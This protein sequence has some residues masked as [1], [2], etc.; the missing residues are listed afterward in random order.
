MGRKG[1]AAMKHEPITDIVERK[2]DNPL[3]T[4][5]Q[6]LHELDTGVRDAGQI[7]V[8]MNLRTLMGGF[9]R[10][11][12]TEAQQKAAARL[13]TLHERAQVG[14]ARAVDPSREPVDGGWTNPEA[15][16]EIG[17]DA[18]KAYI[19][20]QEL[21]GPVDFRRAEYVVIDEHGPTAYARWRLRGE[22]EINGRQV[23]ILQVEVRGIMD[24]L[25]VH[26]EYQS[27]GA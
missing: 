16:F 10:F 7:P 23:G 2:V 19:I 12:G 14:A 27:K 11:H 15:N 13:K 8:A 6:F 25:A 20:A 22:R 24:R 4:W 5:S 9:C 18:R 17:A 21:L 1:Q 3:R 26:W